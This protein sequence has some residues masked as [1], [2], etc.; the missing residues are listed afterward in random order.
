[1]YHSGR[2]CDVK[3]SRSNLTL[4]TAF[5]AEVIEHLQLDEGW[6]KALLAAIANESSRPDNTLRISRI[7]AAI[8]KLRKRHL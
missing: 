1:M 8:G 6:R 4:Q 2:R 3:P 7:E 5:G